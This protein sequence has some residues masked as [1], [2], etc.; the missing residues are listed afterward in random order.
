MTLVTELYETDSFENFDKPCSNFGLIPDTSDSGE[1]IVRNTVITNRRGTLKLR[2][3]Q[4]FIA[5][6]ASK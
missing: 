5:D 1:K 2:S 4:E 3:A 6:Y